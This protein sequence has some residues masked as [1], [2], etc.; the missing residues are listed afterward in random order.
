MLPTAHT[1]NSFPPKLNDKRKNRNCQTKM[2]RCQPECQVVKQIPST[3]VQEF[4][5][6]KLRRLCWLTLGV[7]KGQGHDARPRG[8]RN[9]PRASPDFV[10]VTSSANLQT[11]AHRGTDV[12]STLFSQLMPFSNPFPCPR[13]NLSR[14]SRTPVLFI[15][16]SAFAF[17]CSRWSRPIC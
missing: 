14:S 2:P 3:L 13:Q 15:F 1:Q 6:E 12:P 11:R 5:N 7:G 8:L 9:S 4:C 17:I 16:L 10:S